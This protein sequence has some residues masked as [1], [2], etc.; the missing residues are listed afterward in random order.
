MRELVPIGRYVDERSEKETRAEVP[1]MASVPGHVTGH[2][3][4]CEPLEWSRAIAIR[5]ARRAKGQP[6]GA[7]P[8]FRTRAKGQRFGCWHS[9]GRNAVFEKTGKRTGMVVIRGK[10]SK[11]NCRPGED[12]G[13]YF[14]IRIHVRVSQPIRPYTSIEV[15]W[16]DRTLVFVNLPPERSAPERPGAAVGIDAGVAHAYATSDGR[17]YDLPVE[18]LR[19]ISGRL[20]EAQR[21]MARS[22]RVA[23]A[24]GRQFWESKRYQ[25]AKARGREASRRMA[26]I[27]EDF[28]DKTTSELVDEHEMLF[29]EDLRLREMTAKV[30]GEGAARGR[31]LNRGMLDT[32]IGIA[33]TKLAYKATTGQ[34]VLLAVP[35]H[36]SSQECSAC[37]HVDAANRPSQAVFRCTRCGHTA[38][39]DTNAAQVVLA[40]GIAT[41]QALDEEGRKKLRGGPPRAGS[42]RKRGRA[43]QAP[44]ATAENREPV[45]A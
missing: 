26:A 15:N 18:R 29:I 6:P 1:F 36:Y 24:Q 8:G 28:W 35:P 11:A 14:R 27:R 17:F 32:G 38:N 20:R 4:G 33:R 21:S 43:S 9:N 13:C 30:S 44:T 25:R 37:G 22:R 3:T 31:A 23:A 16:T 34:R 7:M 45:G 12:V 5:R 19:E 10:N 2:P 42:R 40:R 39:A 41:W